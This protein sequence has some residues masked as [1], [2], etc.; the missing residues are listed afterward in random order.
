[1]FE[2]NGDNGGKTVKACSEA[3]LRRQT[4]LSGHGST[5]ICKVLSWL[6][7]MDVVL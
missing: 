7:Q 2:G 1:M 3:C 6:Q 4:A 5:L